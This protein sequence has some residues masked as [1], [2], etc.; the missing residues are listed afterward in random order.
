VEKWKRRRGEDRE[1]EEDE[2]EC[3]ERVEREEGKVGGIFLF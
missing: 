2:G 3:E 1:M